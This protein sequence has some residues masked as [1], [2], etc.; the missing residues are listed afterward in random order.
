MWD[1]VYVCYST[2]MCRV[3]LNKNSIKSKALSNYK[4]IAHERN[5]QAP[6]TNNNSLLWILTILGKI[7]YDTFKVRCKKLLLG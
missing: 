6:I 1:S 2:E 5:N 4:S 3:S 7:I